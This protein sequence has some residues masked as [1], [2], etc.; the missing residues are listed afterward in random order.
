MT[1]EKKEKIEQN[2]DEVIETS[3]KMRNFLMDEKIPLEE[4]KNQL[5]VLRGVLEF[6]RNIVSASVVD[7][8]LEDFGN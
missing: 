6:N 2:M 4:K 5:K 7:L 3:K 8:H 1:N